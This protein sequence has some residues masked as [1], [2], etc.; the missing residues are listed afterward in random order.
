MKPLALAVLLACLL[1]CAPA[2]HAA[3]RIRIAV[4]PPTGD[5]KKIAEVHTGEF[6][7]ENMIDGTARVERFD[8]MSSGDLAHALEENAIAPEDV[9]VE[10]AADLAKKLKVRLLLFIAVRKASIETEVEDKVL[11]Q[12][13]TSVA[14]ACLEGTLFDAATGQTTKIGPFE[15]EERAAGSE[16]GKGPFEMTPEK[17]EK[18]VKTAI[19][20]AAK[21]VR[22]RLYRI[23]PLAGVVTGAGEKGVRLDI[24][25]EMGVAVGQKYIVYGIVERDNPATGLK[26]KARGEIAQLEV[27]EVEEGAAT[28]KVIKGEPSPP[29]GSA[30][31]RNLRE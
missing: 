13:E 17:R 5:I 19:E 10:S 22:A 4:P 23:Y 7:Q 28:C 31:E 6:V 25:K 20:N 12:T 16:G 2:L 24:G 9:K 11:V 27:T 30:V 26:E 8:V 18:L 29:I 14:T 21:K 1:A 3:E 15:E